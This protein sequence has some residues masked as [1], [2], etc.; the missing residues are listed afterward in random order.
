MFDDMADIEV[1]DD[2]QDR[3][4]MPIPGYSN[5]QLDDD[6]D[7]PSPISQFGDNL[8]MRNQ[9]DWNVSSLEKVFWFIKQ[10]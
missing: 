1:N 10:N 5:S 3:R 6:N 4:A 2:N 7:D 8:K 9:P